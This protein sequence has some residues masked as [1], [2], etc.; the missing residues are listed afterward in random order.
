MFIYNKNNIGGNITKKD[1]RYILK[2]NTNLNNL[3]LSNTKLYIRERKQQ[4]MSILAKKKF[5]SLAL[6][7]AQ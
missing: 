7:L 5:I 3:I 2:D 4:D 1:E 6:A